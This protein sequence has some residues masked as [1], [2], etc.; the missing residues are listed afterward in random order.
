FLQ[1]LASLRLLRIFDYLSTVSGGGYAGAWFAAW[2]KREGSAANVEK[3]LDPSR[4]S[5][6]SAH[7]VVREPA[8][9]NTPFTTHVD[10]EPE[11][12]Y[13][14]R[15]YANYLT[16]RSGLLSADTWTLVASYLRNTLVNLFALFP[17][18]AVFV[19]LSRVIVW[20]Y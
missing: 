2:V 13:H 1:G 18:L 8:D 7:R 5:Q 14:V 19:A 10:Q 4:L 17:M 3:Q 6:A 15:A 11:A 9:P 20:F 16:P 12:V